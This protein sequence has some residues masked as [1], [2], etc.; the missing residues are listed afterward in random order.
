MGEDKDPLTLSVQQHPPHFL[1]LNKKE[2]GV[3]LDEGDII[4]CEWMNGNKILC[5]E[6]T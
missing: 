2:E 6:G 4:K 1:I 5:V 3:K